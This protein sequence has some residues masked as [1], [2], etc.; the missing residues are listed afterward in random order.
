MF[1]LVKR[2]EDLDDKYELTKSVKLVDVKGYLQNEYDRASEREEM[3]RELEKKIEEQNEIEL[4]YNAMLVIQEETQ[5]RIERQDKLIKDLR[6]EIKQRDDKIKLS[7]SAQIDIKVNAEK[8]LKDK[9]DD[10]KELK[11]QIKE[12]EKQ[13]KDFEKQNKETKTTKTTRKKKGE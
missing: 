11:K 10:I 8:R 12:L 2:K 5:K 3:I 9:D 13:L 1:G 7:Q 4:K 6:E